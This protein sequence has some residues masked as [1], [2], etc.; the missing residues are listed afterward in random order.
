MQKLN[1]REIYAL[2]ILGLATAILLYVTLQDIFGNI[3]SINRNAEGFVS[4]NQLDL[5]THIKAILQVALNIT[6]CVL[7]F[8]KKPLGWILTFSILLIYAALIGYLWAVWGDLGTTTVIMLAFG[9][10]IFLACNVFLLIPSTIKKFRV[11][12]SA[13]LGVLITLGLLVVLYSGI[14]I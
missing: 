6:A 9:L 2:V 12:P 10:A 1:G 4:M 3:S 5:R 8:R 14:L 13:V 7:F 11:R